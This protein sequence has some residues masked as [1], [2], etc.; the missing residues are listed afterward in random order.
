M[1]NFSKYNGL[2]PA[3]AQDYKTKEI[4]M[5]AYINQEA[6]EHTLKTRKATYYSRSRSKLWQKGE[7]SGNVQ[8]IREIRVDCDEDCVI[9]LIEQVG[10]IACHT[11]HRSCF[12]R[13]VENGQLI[14]FEERLKDPSDI[15]PKEIYKK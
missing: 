12:F 13:K 14:Q 7:S 4:L 5:M 6:W 2:I 11:G 8:I 9:Y 3:I 1:L 15:Y 10:D